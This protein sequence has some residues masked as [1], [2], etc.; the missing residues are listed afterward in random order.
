VNNK[1]SIITFEYL[2]KIIFFNTL[3]EM[4]DVEK[5]NTFYSDKGDSFFEKISRKERNCEKYSLDLSDQW[6]RCHKF[7]N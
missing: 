3:L 2:F 4:I 7:D 1:I 6:C 5:K